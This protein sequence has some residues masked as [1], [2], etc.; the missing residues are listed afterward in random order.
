[1]EF[2]YRTTARQVNRT[3]EK[4]TDGS[5]INGQTLYYDGMVYEGLKAP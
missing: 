2:Y 5:R 1:M 3:S 4:A